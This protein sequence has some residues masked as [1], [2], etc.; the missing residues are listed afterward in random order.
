MIKY[1]PG[2]EVRFRLARKELT[3]TILESYDPRVVLLKLDSGYNIGIPLDKILDSKILKKFKEVEISDE[4]FVSRK[5]G[6]K[7][8]GLVVTGGTIASKLDVKTGGVKPLTKLKEFANFYPKLF[9]MVDVKKIEIPFM[10]ASENMS[11]EHWIKIAKSVEKLLNDKEIEGVIVTHGTDT[12]HYTSAALSFFLKDL[13]KPVVLT[14]SQRSIDRASSDADLNLIC[15]AKMALSNV[16]EVMLVGHASTNDDFCFA[17]KGTKTRKMHTSRRDSF[18]TINDIP[19]A[20][21]WPEKIEFLREYNLRNNKRKVNLDVNF[22]DKVSLIKYY[23]GQKANILD[24]LSEKCKGIIIE[25][26]G[27]GHFASSES[28]NNWI[29]KIKKLIK[30]GVIICAVPQTL[31]GGLNPNVYSSGREL[32][33]CGIIFLKDMLPETAFIKLGWVLGHRNWKGKEK[34]KMLNNFSGELSELLTE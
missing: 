9:D 2:D 7:K 19:I 28:K 25:A 8:I 17:L 12:L 22:S 18:K 5:K 34:E 26:T 29:P 11:S 33:E 31:Y 21:V 3:G 23:P 1:S 30:K 16:A 32:K 14:Y 24:F 10:M 15:A 4:D 20:K 13:N 6:L 27:L